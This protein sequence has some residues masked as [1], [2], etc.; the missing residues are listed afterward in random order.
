MTSLRRVV[1]DHW[2]TLTAT[3]PAASRF[4]VSD[5]SVTTSAGAVSVALDGEGRR[6]LLIPL[7]PERTFEPD[8]TSAGVHLVLRELEAG[9]EARRFADLV[10]NESRLEDVFLSLCADV[11]AAVAAEPSESIKAVK[12]V[13]ASWRSLLDAPR[14]RFG[15]G[16]AAGLFGELVVLERVLEL[17]PGAVSTWTGP[18]GAAHDFQRLRTAVE[19][20]AT[21]TYDGMSFRVH[22]L[23][24][25]DPGAGRLWVA[26]FRLERHPE[27]GVSLA[28][29]SRRV[30]DL[31]DDE[32]ALSGALLRAG[33][34]AAGGAASAVKYTVVDEAW[35]V[36][37][38]SFPRLVAGDLRDGVVRP[39]VSDVHY[40]V[41]FASARVE[42]VEW[43]D[44]LMTMLGIR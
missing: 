14:S 41:D 37:D 3:P 21:T 4:A 12:R 5:T 24:Q 15:P 16:G 32:A 25:L 35:A 43:R 11:L 1:R 20:K 36:V 22:G 19:V 31:C 44:A 27:V 8:T 10:L 29:A 18:F 39:G 23:D 40:T 9:D 38:E 26:W 17:D 28:E 42:R 2:A 13:L 30:L 6:H 34:E 33:Y 7:G